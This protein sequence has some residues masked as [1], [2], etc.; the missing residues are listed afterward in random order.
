MDYPIQGVADL[1]LVTQGWG[2]SDEKQHW[3]LEIW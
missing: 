2:G 1:V 3:S